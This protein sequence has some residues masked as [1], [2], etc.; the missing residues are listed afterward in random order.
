MVVAG[1][2]ENTAAQ[3]LQVAEYV[4]SQLLQQQQLWVRR[5]GG[6]GDGESESGLP[7]PGQA[8]GAGC[9]GS[10]EKEWVGQ[11]GGRLAH[12]ESYTTGYIQ[13]LVTCCSL[14]IASTTVAKLDAMLI[15]PTVTHVRDILMRLLT[16]LD[17]AASFRTITLLH[18]KAQRAHEAAFEQSCVEEH[19][20][21]DFAAMLDAFDG[22]LEEARLNEQPAGD[23]AATAPPP[24]AA[25]DDRLPRDPRRGGSPLHGKKRRKHAVRQPADGLLELILKARA[26]FPIFEEWMHRAC[27]SKNGSGSDG[28]SSSSSG[29]GSSDGAP[30]GGGGAASSLR[31]GG[32]ALEFVTPSKPIVRTIV[33]ALLIAEPAHAQTAVGAAAHTWRRKTAQYTGRD[34]FKLLALIDYAGQLDIGAVVVVCTSYKE[35]KQVICRLF[36]LSGDSDT[37]LTVV[38]AENTM[39]EG[40][41][42]VGQ[43]REVLL[44]VAVGQMPGAIIFEVRIVIKRVATKSGDSSTIRPLQQLLELFAYMEKWGSPSTATSAAAAA[45]ARGGKMS[46]AAAAAAEKAQ[47]EED[48]IVLL[49]ENEKLRIRCDENEVR[50]AALEAQLDAVAS[51][52]NTRSSSTFGGGRASGGGGGG[53]GSGGGGGGGGGDDVDAAGESSALPR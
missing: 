22:C 29:S 50:I 15:Q 52:R 11:L 10:S 44:N 8:D 2:A 53:G 40:K 41:L 7:G 20:R 42:K 17:T 5:R 12:L 32:I 19:D 14:P 39:G 26:M 31:G 9:S 49:Q 16:E 24:P 37:P 4:R 47:L 27:G 35:M 43:C 48:N 36:K 25:P 28:S 13:R 3:V 23:G 1:V 33:E 46:A 34:S 30:D 38:K 45:A 51:R 21:E 6:G 18:K